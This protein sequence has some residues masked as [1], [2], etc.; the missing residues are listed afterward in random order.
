VAQPVQ[1][2]GTFP[3]RSSPST[4]HARTRSRSGSLS[5]LPTEIP[6]SSRSA[7]ARSQADHI[8][9][10]NDTGDVTLTG[11]VVVTIGETDERIQASHGT[12]NIHTETG[13]FYDV[14]GSVG[15]R[16]HP[17]KPTKPGSPAAPES[18]RY[19]NGNPFLFTGQGWW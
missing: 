7:T 17:A 5:I 10:D 9:Y 4:R 6:W 3:S 14:T 13:R 18:N 2:P 16:Q 15:L 19:V 12:I 8:E 1:L 11:N